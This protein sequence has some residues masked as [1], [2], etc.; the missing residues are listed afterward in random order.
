M[1]QRLL[2]YGF[3]I[4]QCSDLFGMQAKAGKRKRSEEIT[5]SLIHSSSLSSSSSSSSA[6]LQQASSSSSS[7]SAA[8]ITNE[9][10]PVRAAVSTAAQV[11]SSSSSSS[12]PA[13]ATSYY[14][15]QRKSAIYNP[16][17]AAFKISRSKLEN[18]VQCRK[19]FYIDRKL[20]TGTPPGYPFSLN[21]AV[22]ELCKKEFDV[23]RLIQQPHP[24]CI[25]AGIDAVPFKHPDIEKWRNS[26][27]QGL[28]AQVPGTN[29]ILQGGIDDVWQD[30]TTGKLMVVDYKATAK[31]GEVSLDADWQQ[32]YKRQVEVYQYLL[33]RHGHDV[34]DTA[35]FVYANGRADQAGFDDTLKFKTKLLPYVG[36]ATW[37]E[38]AVVEA[39]ECLQSDTIPSDLQAQQLSARCQ[40][41]QYFAARVQH[42]APDSAKD[43]SK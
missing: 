17:E 37:V 19:C 6:W 24:L 33:R 40:M 35:Y 10:S 21:S 42:A 30:R 31:K 25:A 8:V 4:A 38:P 9:S 28:Q 34:S 12:A 32:G 7:S 41:C 1:V 3:L 20:G 23:Y 13:Q 16:A 26:L 14:N 39:Y 2:V 22:D 36:N 27:S 43:L 15:P 29:I 18:F 5:R 11:T